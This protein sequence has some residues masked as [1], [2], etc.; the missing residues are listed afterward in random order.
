VDD[1]ASICLAAS[2]SGWLLLHES[3]MITPIEKTPGLRRPSWTRDGIGK[4]SD[5]WPRHRSRVRRSARRGRGGLNTT[6]TRS[7]IESRTRI[8]II[9]ADYRPLF[10]SRSKGSTDRINTVS[11]ATVVQCTRGIASWILEPSKDR[12]LEFASIGSRRNAGWRRGV[13]SSSVRFEQSPQSQVRSSRS[14]PEKGTRKIQ[15]IDLPRSIPK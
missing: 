8:P 11:P 15:L 12:S 2:R 1:G 3:W 9:H 6:R 14:N 4:S 5:P 13:R 10:L 7:L